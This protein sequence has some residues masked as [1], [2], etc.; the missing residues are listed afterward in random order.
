MMYLFLF[1]ITF[2][3]NM[4]FT[5]VSRSR[6][7]GNPLRHSIAAVFSNGVWFICNY[8][9]LFPEIMKAIETGD[10]WGKM[11]MLLIYVSGT[12]LGSVVMMKINLGHYG[13]VP[14]LTET[15]NSKVGS[16]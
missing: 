3:Q 9:I 2:I 10:F 6:N 11:I 4:F 14:F 7:S 16:I 8:F 13:H 15:G 5:W 1:I 12:T